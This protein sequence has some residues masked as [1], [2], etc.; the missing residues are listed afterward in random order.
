MVGEK[1][2]R[3]WLFGGNSNN[4]ADCGLAAAN[5]NNVW[6]NANANIS[7]RHTLKRNLSGCYYC[8]MGKHPITMSLGSACRMYS[9]C[10]RNN[11]H[12]ARLSSVPPSEVLVNLNNEKLKALHRE[13]ASA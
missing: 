3:L 6:S 12:L 9:A 10:G 8:V 13:K 4:G 7:A 5:S 11:I 1:V 2:I